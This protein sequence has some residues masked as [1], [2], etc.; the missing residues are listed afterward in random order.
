[1]ENGIDWYFF[2]ILKLLLNIIIEENDLLKDY[3]EYVCNLNVV[4]V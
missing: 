4:Y 1:M 2:G 3:S